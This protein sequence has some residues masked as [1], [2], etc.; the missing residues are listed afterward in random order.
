MKKIDWD[1]KIIGGDGVER[2]REDIEKSF[3]N[4]FESTI[5]R[6]LGDLR[7]SLQTEEFKDY[8]DYILENIH[9][10]LL[11]KPTELQALKILEDQ[12]KR[13]WINENGI[14]EKDIITFYKKVHKA[15][16]YRVFRKARLNKI[17]VM[18]NVKTCL[19]CNQQYTIALGK[20]IED[21]DRI[22]LDGAKAFL[23][24]DHFFGEAEYPIMSMSLYNLIPC[25]PFCNQKKSR[26]HISL[27]LH[28]Y[29]ED[30]S[31]MLRFRIKNKESF[32]NPKIKNSDLLE[33]EID[34]YGDEE[35][36]DFVDKLD[37]EKR[38]GRHL[39]IVQ[40][41]EVA[42]YMEPY[43]YGHFKD[44]NQILDK[45]CVC[46]SEKE[47]TIERHF[48]G[49]YADPEDINRSP[50]TKFSQDVYLQLTSWREDNH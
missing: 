26:N 48:K 7:S 11:Y 38:Y 10:I 43:Y 3:T 42:L 22:S 27:K 40:D 39:D 30:L 36:R 19:Y 15:F 1:K 46:D 23:Q 2:S 37:L 29:E 45:V 16:N 18:L 28:P 47:K 49:F 31:S 21:D 13:R 35:V 4:L 25:C 44:I 34:T 33:V 17:A 50:L 5:R 41:M 24:F 20:S 12:R 6:K 9:R 14:R 32:I 8:I